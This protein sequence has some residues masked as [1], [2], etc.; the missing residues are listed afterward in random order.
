MADETPDPTQ[1]AEAIKGLSDD[2]LKAELDKQGVDNT[3]KQI[4]SGMEQAFAPDKAKGVSAVVQWDVAVNGATKTWTVNIADG[5]CKVSESAA[6]NPRL[7][8]QVNLVDFIRM[9][10]RQADGTQLFM[11]GKLKLKGDMMFAMQYQNFFNAP[12]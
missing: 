12:A 8:F 9:I 1:I 4:F 3:L 11:S 10:F 6:D 5:T 2:E 7:T